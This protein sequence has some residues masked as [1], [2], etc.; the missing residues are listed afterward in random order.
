MMRLS[1]KIM[2][3]FFLDYPGHSRVMRGIFQKIR[4]KTRT[5]WEKVGFSEKKNGFSCKNVGF[6]RESKSGRP[7]VSLS[8]NS[9]HHTIFGGVDRASPCSMPQ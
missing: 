7:P 5:I 1:S 9:L 8:D 4:E 3:F 2:R 6:I